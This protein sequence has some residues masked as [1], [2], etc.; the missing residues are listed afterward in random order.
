MRTE[1]AVELR[2]GRHRARIVS[3][4]LRPQLVRAEEDHCRIGLLATTALLL[5]GDE[6]DLVVT[7]GPR[8]TLDLFDVAGTVAYHGRGRPAAWRVAFTLAEAAVLHYAGEPFV[9][10]DGADVART[11]LVDQAGTATAQIRDTLVLGRTGEAGGRLHSHTAVRVDGHEV[12]REDQ[13]LDVADGRCSPGL[14][15][16]CRVLDTLIVLGAGAA[17]DVVP[18]AVR[19][20]LVGGVGT[21]TRFL[22]T[23]LAASPV[24][25]GWRPRSQPTGP[26][27]DARTPLP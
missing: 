16:D 17:P 5:G 21:V 19:F 2:D 14:L 10:A 20:G 4:L 18:P 23:E 26:R 8:A 22:G 7:V 15:G 13:L 3:G 24:R 11:M 12:W 27:S 25:L 6:V 1:I 9:V